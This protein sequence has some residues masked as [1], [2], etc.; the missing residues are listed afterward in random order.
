MGNPRLSFPKNNQQSGNCIYF[1]WV[2][3]FGIKKNIKKTSLTAINLR[4]QLNGS[5]V[6][7]NHCRFPSRRETPPPFLV[8]R[9]RFA[10]FRTPQRFNRRFGNRVTHE[11]HHLKQPCI[12]QRTSGFLEGKTDQTTEGWMDDYREDI[13]NQSML[14]VIF[15]YMNLVDVIY[16]NVMVYF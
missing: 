10:S 9:P 5:Q 1:G 14:M 6:V 15:T 4:I 3:A 8:S 12:D 16:V 2:F 11:L 7:R 13:Q